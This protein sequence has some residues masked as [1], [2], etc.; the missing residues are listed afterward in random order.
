MRR[1]MTVRWAA[2]FLMTV[3]LIGCRH[4]PEPTPA[5]IVT[6]PPASAGPRS[7]GDSIVASGEIVPAQETE[8]SFT[9]SGRVRSVA[10]VP[11]NEVQAG[12]VLVQL[13]RDLLEAK[14]TE[15]EAALAAARAD[16]AL[17]K[18][19]PRSEEIAIAQAQVGV[20]EGALAQAVTQRDQPDVGATEA[21][22]AAAQGQVATATADRVL[23]DHFHDQTMTCVNVEIE[24]EEKTICPLLGPMEE[25]A[26]YR[27]HATQ[28]AQAA[29][30]AQLDA[31]LAGGDAEVRRAQASVQAAAARHD[32]ARADL[33]TL[34]AGATTEEI[35]A[36]EAAVNRAEATARAARVALEQT[37][38]RAPFAG[39]VTAAQISVGEAAMPGQTVMALAHLHNLQAQTTDLSERDV[40]R[41]GVGQRAT[42]YVEA[43]DAEV[44]G[45]VVR[46]APQANTVGGDVMYTITIALDGQPPGL[47]WGMSVEVEI[48]AG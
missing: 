47:R 41:V 26:R 36:A 21:E 22:V 8:M 40:A 19:P 42:V 20:A 7:T 28:A 33:D 13:E 15:A 9:V 45:L 32:A 1:I 44:E 25:Q 17:V 3:A 34:R 2:G 6:A 12:D 5:P 29:A 16:L 48:D 39:T 43:L 10:V 37:T 23:A 14:V 24:G 31:L 38:L 46:I 18:A 35:A 30:Q 11:G 4:S 27:W